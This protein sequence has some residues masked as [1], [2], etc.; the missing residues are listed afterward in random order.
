MDKTSIQLLI[1]K[2][3]LTEKRT[4]NGYQLLA[5]DNTVVFEVRGQMKKVLV[6]TWRYLRSLD[7]VYKTLNKTQGMGTYEY[8]YSS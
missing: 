6:H 4:R 3:Q 7:V 8:N 1:E 5:C 2:H